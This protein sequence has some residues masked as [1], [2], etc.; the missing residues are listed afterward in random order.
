M[1]TWQARRGLVAHWQ[2]SIHQSKT[3][4]TDTIYRERLTVTIFIEP[5][6]TLKQFAA[7]GMLGREYRY[8]QALCDLGM[9]VNLLS[10]G[11]RSEL[12]CAPSSPDIRVLCNHWGF[13]ERSYARRVH[14]IHA[15]PLLRTHVLRSRNSIHSIRPALPTHWAWQIPI[16]CRATMMWS[17]NM[18]ALPNTRPEQVREAYDYESMVFAKVT[19]SIALT[20]ALAAAIIER[21]P[22]AADKITVIPSHVD[23]ELFQPLD[24]EKRYDLI[25]V[26]WLYRVKNLEAMLEAV[27]RTG[28]TI[29]IA[30]DSSPGPHGK[31]LEPEV[32]A[33]LQARFGNL[34]GRIHWL[35]RKPNEEMPAYINQAK[36]MILVSHSEG[37]GRVIPEA[38]A[39][40]VPVIGSKVGGIQSTLRHGETGWLCDTDVDSIATAIETVLSQPRLIERMGANARRYALETYSMPAIARQEYELLLDI[41]RRNPVES[42]ARR[43]AKYIIRRR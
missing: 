27:E 8:L 1:A 13:P 3:L 16:V 18:A 11:G 33:R 32:K 26:G 22:A 34:D 2:K 6:S 19:H 4:M 40:G 17:T 15:L 5:A 29:A 43:I 23:C 24:S 9:R 37:F 14:Q 25:Y 10:F 28:A 20:P 30:G 42:A 12:D 35:G 38:M 21:A 41:V 39:C 31:A 7:R 36:A